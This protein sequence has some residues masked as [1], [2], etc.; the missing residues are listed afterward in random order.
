MKETSQNKARNKQKITVL[1]Q[2]K[3]KL[4]GD[5]TVML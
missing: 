5:K 4:T 1:I 2:V 3:G